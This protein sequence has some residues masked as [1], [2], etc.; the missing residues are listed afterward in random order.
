M[1]R[2]SDVVKPTRQ[3]EKEGVDK[4]HVNVIIFYP[5]ELGGKLERFT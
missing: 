2:C 3:L 1:Q 5:N 4:D